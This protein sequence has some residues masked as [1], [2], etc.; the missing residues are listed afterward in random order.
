MFSDDDTP[1]VHIE[2]K[3]GRLVREG[4]V[5]IQY[6]FFQS[7]V[8]CRVMG[9]RNDQVPIHGINL[10]NFIGFSSQMLL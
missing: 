5:A 1:I 10:M 2:E 7:E 4:G 3:Y 9:R 8:P 6:A